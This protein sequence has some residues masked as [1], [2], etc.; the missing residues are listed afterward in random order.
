MQNIVDIYGR[1][2][3]KIWKTLSTHGP[4]DEKSIIKK[5]RLNKNDFYIGVGW[6]ARENKIF[7]NGVVYQLSETNLTE[8][9][10]C[11]AGKVWNTLSCMLNH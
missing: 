5:G 1:N 11:D 7:K 3:G 2:A 10:G 9:I 4:L 8:K 6:L